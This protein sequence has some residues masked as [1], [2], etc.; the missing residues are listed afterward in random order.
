MNVRPYQPEDEPILREIWERA[1]YGD[2]FPDNLSD[3]FVVTDDG[4]CPIMAAGAKLIPEMTLICAPGGSTHAL[5]KV[6]GL[7]LLHDQ[8]R[9]TLAAK[10]YTEAIASV[11]PQLE[12]SYGRHL[13]R[14]F[15]WLLS[16]TTY[17][18]RDW[19]KDG[20]V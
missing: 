13:Q 4:G 18:I 17:R 3:Y 8:L 20:V 16:W 1:A 14:H 7:C 5:V 9:D 2:E 19:K 11:P 15:R 6:R 12:R 10:G